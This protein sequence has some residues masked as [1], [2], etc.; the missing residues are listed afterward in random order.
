MVNYL[1]VIKNFFLKKIK[2]LYINFFKKTYIILFFL[3]LF[4]LLFFCNLFFYFSFV[5]YK[6][7]I[8]L[9]NI[10]LYVNYKK[11]RNSYIYNLLNI[12]SLVDKK[13]IPIK[14][15]L[16]NDLLNNDE[17]IIN[18]YFFKIK[19]YNFIFNKFG[20]IG[21]ISS[22]GDNFSKANFICKKYND[23]YFQVL[24]NGVMDFIP[25]SGC[26]SDLEINDVF[27]KFNFEV[28]DI[29]IISGMYNY[30]FFNYPI[31]IIKNIYLSNNF[32][33]KLI[34]LKSFDFMKGFGYIYLF[35]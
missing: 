26:L 11:L 25:N 35:L 13:Y 3:I 19:D 10:V 31:G 17:F 21:K 16:N 9:N 12:L 15:F 4:I 32:N 20:F 30:L 18:H 23:I 29:L 2:Y 22:I 8:L 14:F 28:G 7:D 1:V 5:S 34:R 24:R 27:S 6:K 33:Y